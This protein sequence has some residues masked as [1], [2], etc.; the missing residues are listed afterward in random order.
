MLP[1]A[2]TGLATAGGIT[3]AELHMAGMATPSMCPWAPE[4]SAM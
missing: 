4:L 1:R 2:A 3:V